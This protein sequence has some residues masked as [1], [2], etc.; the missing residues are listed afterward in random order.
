L[1]CTIGAPVTIT[2]VVGP[3]FIM[4]A[5]LDPQQA[6][7]ATAKPPQKHTK[8]CRIGEGEETGG[9]FYLQG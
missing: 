3:E 1:P 5:F 4:G 2:V 9:V 7:Q 6:A 8:I